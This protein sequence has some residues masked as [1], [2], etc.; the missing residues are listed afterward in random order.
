MLCKIQAEAEETLPSVSYKLRLKKQFHMLCKLQAE[1]E[2]TVPSVS[3]KL[4]LKKQF[5]MLCKLQ[6]VAEKTFEHQTSSTVNIES[7]LKL[8][9]NMETSYS[10]F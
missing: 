8:L 6:A 5:H 10:V 7:I 3:Y 2:E 1:A 9:L 4:R